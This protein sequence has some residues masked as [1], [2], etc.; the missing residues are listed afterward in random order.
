MV[1]LDCYSVWVRADRDCLG[2]TARNALHLV[3]P[4]SLSSVLVLG[5]AVVLYTIIN[6]RSSRKMIH[7]LY[8]MSDILKCFTIYAFLTKLSSYLLSIV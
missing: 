4:F 6:S 2:R 8:E 1:H 5:S 3:G 7:H